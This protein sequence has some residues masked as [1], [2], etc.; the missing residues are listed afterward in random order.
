MDGRGSILC[1]SK[2]FFYFPF[3]FGFGAH[4]TSYLVYIGRYFPRDKNGRGPEAD[5]LPPFSAEV[6][7]GEG[8]PP[9]PMHLHG[10][11]IN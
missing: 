10:V 7:N 6:K 2:R 4:P 9:H 11:I 3:Q 8:I 1:R 5:H